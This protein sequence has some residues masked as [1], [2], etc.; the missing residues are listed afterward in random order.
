MAVMA[1]LALWLGGVAEAAWCQ[2]QGPGRCWACGVAA[3][4]GRIV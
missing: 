2:E 3:A 1:V 4:E